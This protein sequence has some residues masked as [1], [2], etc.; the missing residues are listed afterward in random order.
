MQGPETRRSLLVQIQDVSQHTAWQEFVTIYEP[1]VYRLARRKGLQHADAQ[2]LTQ[3]VFTTVQTA[4]HRFDP[5]AE[6]G[7]FRGWLFRIARNLMI[8]FLTRQKEPRGSGDTRL[9]QMLHE[10]AAEESEAATQFD[11]E[12]RRELFAWAAQQARSHFS[13][14]NW[15]AFW[16]T[17]VEGES[18]DQVAA[19]LGKPPGSV[20]VARCRVLAKLKHYAQQ[21]DDTSISPKG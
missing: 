11:L 1:L 5:D 3:D 19:A 14:E 20:R 9:L 10:H 21:M 4:I 15:Q 7:T 17:G 2:D 13:E 8:N 12:Y 16:R 18:I 6:T